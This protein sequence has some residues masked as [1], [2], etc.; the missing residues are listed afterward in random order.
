MMLLM[1]V[2]YALNALNSSIPSYVRGIVI[3]L[4]HQKIENKGLKSQAI[5]KI[6]GCK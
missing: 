4:N 2:G 5:K 1:R 3:L 6:T